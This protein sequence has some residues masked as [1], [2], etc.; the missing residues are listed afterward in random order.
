MC[1]QKGFPDKPIDVLHLGVP[2]IQ[3]W[4]ILM[5]KLVDKIRTAELMKKDGEDDSRVQTV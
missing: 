4:K 3:K 1:L 2:Y 5:R